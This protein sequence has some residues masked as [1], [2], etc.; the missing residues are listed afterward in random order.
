MQLVAAGADVASSCTHLVDLAEALTAAAGGPSTPAAVA[1]VPAAVQRMAEALMS[2]GVDPAP[3]INSWQ[4]LSPVTKLHEAAVALALPHRQIGSVDYPARFPPCPWLL[5]HLFQL[6][7]AGGPLAV[8]AGVEGVTTVLKQLPDRPG[9]AAEA[10]LKQWLSLPAALTLG[11]REL[12]SLAGRLLD[13]RMHLGTLPLLLERQEVRDA[14]VQ[15]ADATQLTRFGSI[16]DFVV[17]AAA[18]A[19]APL[20]DAVLAAGGGVSLSAL[21][22]VLQHATEGGPSTLRLLLSCGVPLVP[23]DDEPAHLESCPLY[24]VL[25]HF[26]EEQEGVRGLHA[27][28]WCIHAQSACSSS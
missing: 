6:H 12:L 3:A 8:P 16:S 24:A 2:G 27:R 22:S 15:T 14:L 11:G 28:L 25:Q 23:G 17:A 21:H 20:L 4:L 1:D 26:H 5:D 7:S 9:E 13:R 18:A 19:G 10:A